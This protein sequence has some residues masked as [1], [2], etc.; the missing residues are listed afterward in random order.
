LNGK[1]PENPETSDQ[2]NRSNQILKGGD[3]SRFHTDYDEAFF[4]VKVKMK[5]KKNNQSGFIK[6]EG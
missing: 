4:G 5:M 1:C 2:E 6:E 3:P